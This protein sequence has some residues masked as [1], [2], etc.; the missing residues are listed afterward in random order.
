MSISKK[1]N[2]VFIVLSCVILSIVASNYFNITN[3]REKMDETMNNRIVQ[4]NLL[5]DIRYHVM[6]QAVFSRAAILE[7]TD[8]NINTFIMHR[9][10]L[11]AIVSMLESLPKTE[12]MT[13][14]HEKLNGANI[15]FNAQADTFQ[16]NITAQQLEA[17]E[18]SV[19]GALAS[20]NNLLLGLAD[21][22]LAYQ[23]EQLDLI[24]VQTKQA[25]ETSI[26]SSGILFLLAAVIC[27]AAM[28]Y[29]R[30]T[31]TTPLRYVVRHTTQI[32]AGDLSVN[33][34]SVK[35]N[36]E[37]GQLATAF[38]DM[39]S[40]LYQLITHVQQSTEQLNAS[41]QELSASTEEM[42][43]SVEESNSK[44]TATAQNA[45]TSAIAAT[46]SASAVE[47][48]A[49]GVHRIAQATQH[50]NEQSNYTAEA[51]QSG[52]TSIVEAK[53]QMTKINHS[54]WKLNDLV[55]KLTKQ[56]EEIGQMTKVITDITDQT[57][58]LALNASIEAARAGEYGKGFAVVAEEVRKLAE[59]S[60]RSADSI[61]SLTLDIQ[62]DTKNVG[63]ALY[64]SIDYV[65]DG[66]HI[67]DVAEH[68][69]HAI[70][71]SITDM[72]GQIQDIS[73]TAEQLSVS[74]EQVAASV[75]AIAEKAEE[76]SSHT[77][78]L[79]E[80][81]NEQVKATAQVND[82]A[83]QLSDNAQTLQREINRFTV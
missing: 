14:F 7:P 38:N 81:M 3:V 30:R 69:F 13:E 71:T 41:A 29:I 47:E 46:E 20:A 15:D 76:A 60:K 58:L 82:V 52:V 74:A 45:Q 50:L 8:D 2:T 62:H 28:M 78:V 42:T 4:M 11:D 67:I 54:T 77:A 1:L 32:A 40:N 63:K 44:I 59:E 36:D 24:E 66:V 79:T 25:I 18:L 68:S 16:A 61:T 70:K 65:K 49:S 35:T 83:Y 9:D 22:S 39:K 73:A 26:V 48:T 57:N 43:A 19:N 53:E 10:E 17:A 80:S 33:D 23:G 37:I 64:E 51:V 55:E 34:L 21:E 12:K 27:A 72:T 31:I 75:N 56:S 5:H 6:G